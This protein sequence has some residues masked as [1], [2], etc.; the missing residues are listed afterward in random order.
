MGQQQWLLFF[1]FIS[2]CVK[3][4]SS[5]RPEHSRRRYFHCLVSV[6]V[7]ERETFDHLHTTTTTANF[8]QRQHR[9]QFQQKLQMM[10]MM[11]RLTSCAPLS[12][13]NS[14]RGRSR[15]EEPA[16]CCYV[17]FNWQYR[18]ERWE[19][20]EGHKDRGIEHFSLP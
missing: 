11:R 13:L 16:K 9:H 1:F 7:R 8:K 18:Y 15:G 4:N 12:K 17:S 5:G 20:R 2:L 10:M 14:R 3:S 19:K 6:C